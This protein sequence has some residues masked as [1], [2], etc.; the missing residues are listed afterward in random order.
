MKTYSTGQILRKVSDCCTAVIR[1]GR[2]RKCGKEATT[3]LE[4]WGG[5]GDVVH[6]TEDK[7][8]EMQNS[9]KFIMPVPGSQRN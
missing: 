2:C 6:I 4:I 1:D 8:K 9:L 5:S 7:Y 3:L